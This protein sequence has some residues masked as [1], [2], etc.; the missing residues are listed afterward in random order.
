MSE[1]LTERQSEILKLINER[2]PD[3]NVLHRQ[4][5]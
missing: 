1:P 5:R 3:A 4:R 2:Y